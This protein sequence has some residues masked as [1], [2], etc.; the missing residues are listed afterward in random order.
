ILIL[1]TIALYHELP[2]SE[3][4][5]LLAKLNS[6]NPDYERLLNAHARVHGEMYNRFSFSLGKDTQ[7][8]TTAEELR[9]SSSQQN[10]NDDLLVQLMKSC[11]YNNISSTG[12]N[13]PALQGIWSGTWW[14]AWS[15]DFTLNGNVPSSI[16]GGLNTNFP[17]VTMAYLD[18]MTSWY[19]DYRN[20]AKELYDLDGIFVPSRASDFG[21]CF[22]YIS[23]FPHLYWWTGT[24][25]PSH[26][27]YDYWLFSG[28]QKFLNERAIP[29]MLDAYKFLSQILYEHNG[30]YI[31]IPSYSPEIAPKGKHPIAVNAT[32]DVA[33]MKQLLRNLITLVEQGYIP[34]DDL[35]EYKDIL[36]KLPKY[37]IS[38]KGELK[39]W[40]W[41]DFE[42][43]DEHRH[44]SH[45]YMLYDGLDPEFVENPAL[46]DASLKAIESRMKYRR[47][48]K[49]A[50]MAFG[51]VQ[52]GSAS[53]HL[54]DAALAYESVKWMSSSYWNN[55]LI[56]Y[57]DP[58]SIFNLDI[59]GGLPAVV[60]K[61]IVQ[62]SSSAIDL[63][64]AL[65]ATW[66]KGDIKGVLTRCGVSVDLTW[67][68]GKP[69]SA[70]LTASRDAEFTL[71][72]N[73]ETWEMDL[74]K[75]ETMNWSI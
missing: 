74:K 33:S 32:M 47:E 5:S 68:D 72:F 50:E 19:D 46:V 38:D 14:P 64:P 56:S 18:M 59:S 28:D 24:T 70:K 57:H 30:E 4:E 75:G 36:D 55:A 26:F 2:T 21:N 29:F 35:A 27:F 49:G 52:L 58:G 34:D 54:R 6:L 9:A 42:N 10:F 67:E 7:L 61:M 41:E 16:A 63:L 13:P 22:H 23:E 66:P 17:E 44:A 15:G 12:E 1:S 69:I 3:K 40:I 43:D 25:W 51:L 65:P 73:N 45:F 20:N 39:E 71:K 37:A 8:E 60:T 62:S 11:R 53:A 31:F 48:S